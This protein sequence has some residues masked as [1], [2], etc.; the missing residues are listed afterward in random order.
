MA[1][2]NKDVPVSLQLQDQFPVSMTSD[3]KVVLVNDGGAKVDAKTG[4]L[5]W[6]VKLAPGERREFKFSYEVSVKNGDQR[7]LEELE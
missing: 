5:T 2:N 3:V 4:I 6:D 1:K 7:I